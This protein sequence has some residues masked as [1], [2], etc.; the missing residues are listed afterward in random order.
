MTFLTTSRVPLRITG[1]HEFPVPPLDLDEAVELFTARAR[2]VKPDFDVEGDRHAVVA[3]ICN[4]LD[5]L[6]LAI[7]LA[8]ARIKVLPPRALLARLD[9]RLPLLGDGRS[10]RPERHRTLRTTIDWS[11]ELLDAGQQ[12]CFRA[13]AVFVAGCTL[14]G[15]DAVVGD[16]ALDVFDTVTVLVDHSLMR[17]AGDDDAEEPRFRMLETIREFALEQLEASGDADTVRRRQARWLLDLAQRAR[18]ELRGP[19]HLNWFQ[20]LEDE[21]DNFRAALAWALDHD[22]DTALGIVAALGWFWW[23]HGHAVEGARWAEAALDRA[24]G[25]P[26]PARAA[27]LHELGIL[28]DQQGQHDRARALLEEAL[29]FARASGDRAGEAMELNSLGVVVRAQGDLPAARALF[30]QALAVRRELGDAA[31]VSNALA[32][33]GIVALDL[34]DFG[35]AR[36][37]MEEALAVDRE[38][39][40]GWGI[41]VGLENLGVLEARAGAHERAAPL[42]R[43]AATRLLDLGDEETLTECFDGLAEVAHALGNL[44]RAARLRAVAARLRA[45]LGAALIPAD[46]SAVD[47]AVAALRESLGDSAFEEAWRAGEALS[48]DEATALALSD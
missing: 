4:R 32:N 12:A 34:G 30:E 48:V 15:A 18:P 44:S 47:E 33:L 1:E 36:T 10:D 42:L 28:V 37:Y 16:D 9:Q 3:E 38:R 43:E 5:R 22:L 17:Q 23:T 19:D 20:R 46:Q 6:P 39:G 14:D 35:A 8:A 7:E 40:D 29:D 26:S 41:A 27:V 45:E 31:L 2:A 21:H 11:Y 24:G 25:E 13:F